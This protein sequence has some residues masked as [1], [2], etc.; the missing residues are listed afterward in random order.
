MTKFCSLLIAFSLSFQSVSLAMDDASADKY[1]ADQKTACANNSSMEWNNSLN[2]CVGKA[3]ARATRNE[4]KEC[5]ALTD[6]SAKEK[7]H[8]AS[9]Q[10]KSGLSADTGKLNQGNTTA[11]MVM[12]GAAAAYSVVS[13]ITENGFSLKSSSCTSKN[14]LGITS[15][16]GLA[17]DL[18]LKKRARS[19]VKELEGKYK[20]ETTTNG[21]QGQVKAFEYLREEQ[22]TVVDIAKMEKK[23]NMLLTA[24][25]AL[26]AGFAAYEI[27]WVK[28]PDCSGQ[29]NTTDVSAKA[30]DTV[31]AGSAATTSLP[32]TGLAPGNPIADPQIEA[33]SLTGGEVK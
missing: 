3:Q 17:S 5:E 20:L 28:T 30:T 14:I 22:Q 10:N 2:R 26:A 32:E 23:R 21:Y 9:A 33:R 24:G 7:C 1:I 27:M 31:S 19:K 25:Y 15:A 8:L 11:A 6:V 4:A 12:N 29:T 18:Y 13:L 16:A